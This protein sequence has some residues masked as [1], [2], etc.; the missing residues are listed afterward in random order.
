[1]AGN[2]PDN[3]ASPKYTVITAKIVMSLFGASVTV[4][5]IYSSARISLEGRLQ[6][7]KHEKNVIEQLKNLLPS[8]IGNVFPDISVCELAFGVQ[9]DKAKGLDHYSVE[10][11]IAI[12]DR[13]INF[14]LFNKEGS[15]LV[16]L[17][18]PDLI[19]LDKLPLVGEYLN[20]EDGVTDLQVIYYN[21]DKTYDKAFAG[22]MA[23][24]AVL[25][26]FPDYKA[27]ISKDLNIFAG[28]RIGGF[29]MP[30]A[31]PLKALEDKTRAEI[32]KDKENKKEGKPEEKPAQPAIPVPPKKKFLDVKKTELIYKNGKIGFLFSGAV[33][34]SVFEL[35]V[36][37]LQALAELSI[38][39][40]FSLQKLSFG[41]EGLSINIQKP[42]LSLTGA[43]LRVKSDKPEMADDYFG[44]L[45]VGFK[46]F[47]FSAIGAYSKQADYTSIFVYAFIG[48]PLGGPPFFFVTGLAFGMGINRDFILPDIGK[49]SKFPLLAVCMEQNTPNAVKPPDNNKDGALAMLKLL[50]ES[51]PP[52][53]GSYFLI[54]GIRFESFKVIRTIALAVIKFGHELEINLLGIS[55][56][57]LPSVYVELA[58]S[59][60]F[61]PAR[62]IFMARGLLTANSYVLFPGLK[63]SGG[64]AVGFWFSGD[65][66]GD[67]VV[68]MGGYHPRYKVPSH[69]PDNI[70][71][72]GI[73]GKLDGYV[74]LSGELY[75][76]LTPQAIMA[77]L[78]LN[79]VYSD[80]WLY[81]SISLRADFIVLWKPFYYEAD[82]AVDV[83]VRFT[84]GKGILSKDFSFHLSA[85]LMVWGPEFSGKAFLDAGIKTFKISFGANAPKFAPDLTWDEFRNSFIPAAPCSINV[86]GGLINKVKITL[87]ETGKEQ[88]VWIINPKELE[89]ITDSIIPSTTATLGSDVLFAGNTFP[90]PGIAPI[91]L[92]TFEAQHKVTLYSGWGNGRTAIQKGDA[93]GRKFHFE[94]VTKNLPKAVW[95]KDKP[96]SRNPPDGDNSLMKGLLAGVK[97]TAVESESGNTRDF[98]EDEL[99]FV[100][101]IY[102]TKVNAI[103]GNIEKEA[104]LVEKNISFKD[105]LSAAE[106]RNSSL[107]VLS[108][109]LSEQ[110]ID[111]SDLSGKI[112]V[113]TYTEPFIET[114]LLWNK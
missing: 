112:P 56:L 85:G 110:I 53:S 63:L 42:P 51:I 77:G 74:T 67:F 34:I 105:Y 14:K 73:Y 82:I 15:T 57:S 29:H 108:D 97:I 18:L 94:Q 3:T 61:A 111:V 38:I 55:S 76:A 2:L 88:E 95:G 96:D 69:F 80:G 49:I 27:V 107:H 37:G 92:K 86:T 65:H 58:F 23:T 48:L 35:E 32:A 70:P 102:T 45:N 21:E 66:A 13:K 99:A 64:F 12:N 89:L 113:Y 36:M 100:K 11:T 84:I 114:R 16:S 90:A 46:Q 40:D 25:A 87:Q 101:T 19:S 104:N 5:G 31:Y 41:L 75:F 81:A 6:L 7:Q 72:I 47:Q 44:L 71:R 52:L 1:M 83:Y 4:T 60:Q 68:S 79:V 54:A 91:S 78:S 43:F 39:K 106:T 26:G 98:K 22:L 17:H 8:L 109:I 30:V 9:F 59:V 10:G 103:N 93:L 24:P 20:K 28:I 50:S 62:G 33:S